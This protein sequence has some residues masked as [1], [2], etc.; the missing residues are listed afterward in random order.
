[1]KCVLE[2]GWALRFN[3]SRHA[4][5]PAICQDRFREAKIKDGAAIDAI[6]DLGQKFRQAGAQMLPDHFLFLR[7]FRGNQR[8]L[9]Q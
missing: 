5:I 7:F 9:S 3:Q 8:A 2:D 4:T 1:M 6:F